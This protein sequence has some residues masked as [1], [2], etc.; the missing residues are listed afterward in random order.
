[1]AVLA[2]CTASDAGAQP[3]SPPPSPAAI[4]TPP[5]PPADPIRPSAPQSVSPTPTPKSPGTVSPAP[6][7]PTPATP[8]PDT[9]NP[10]AP[11]PAYPGGVNPNPVTPQI[12]DSVTPTPAYPDDTDPNTPSTP[13]SSGDGQTN[14]GLTNISG[15]VEKAINGFFASLVASAL[16]PLLDVLSR[17]L[18]TTPNPADLPQIGELWNSSWALVLAMYALVVMASGVLLMVHETAQT[19]WSARELVPRLAIGFGA[20]ALSMLIA[21]AAIRFANTLAQAVGGHGV[22][23]NTTGA[24]LRQLVELDTTQSTTFLI[25]LQLAL[26]VIVVILLVS[27]AVRVAITIVLVVGAPLAL[28][29]HALP[30]VEAIARWWWRSFGAC[31]AIQVVQSLVLVTVVRVFLTPGGWNIFGPNANGLVDLIMG[32]ALMGVLAKTPYW[33]LSTLKIGQ[34]R[35]LAGSV[36]RS[37]LTYKTLGLL[38]G[39]GAPKAK[40]SEKPKPTRRRPLK[41]P[42]QPKTA[43]P[44]ARVRATRDG[45]L[46]LPLEGVRRV[47]RKPSPPAS[48]A[49]APKPAATRAPQG[50]Q[51]AFDFRPPDPYR[52]IRAGCDGQ[53]RLPI[54]VT[55]ARPAS[56]PAPAPA[57]PASSPS[58]TR[59]S[60]RERGKQLAFEFT[61]PDP[62]ARLR[63]L[64]N[65]QY[66]LPIRVARVR[67][68]P[69][70]STPPPPPAPAPASGSS[71][72]RQLH[73]PLPDLPV[74]RRAPKGGS[75]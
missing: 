1:M 19:R 41:R 73:L 33:L 31:L 12:P 65:G 43:D 38:K 72:G 53:Y 70:S 44:Y 51:L 39:A 16:N 18:L 58:R 13:D 67:P 75:R 62:Y 56:A 2:A 74:R 17:T 42:A 59:T 46:M 66:P 21:T 57:P 23:P 11:N 35:T 47:P 34:S 63:P 36:I 60:P 22:D 10:A 61:P 7:T 32:I 9:P 26:V 27:Y 49:T 64:R 68:A 69:A 50:R 15:C 28:M 29:C 71:Q 40:P 4:E 5:V 25:M 6:V 30:G 48:P 37:Y 14:C 3:P 8:G 54:P 45:Q 24:A 20:G 52:G 55:R